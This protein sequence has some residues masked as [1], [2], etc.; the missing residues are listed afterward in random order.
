M[1]ADTGQKA[2]FENQSTPVRGAG[3]CEAKIWP[4]ELKAVPGSTS[5]SRA[6]VTRLSPSRRRIVTRPA[7]TKR[8]FS[9]ELLIIPDRVN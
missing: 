8:D 9:P 7:Q 5:A 2:W 3:K 1:A 4:D 6:A